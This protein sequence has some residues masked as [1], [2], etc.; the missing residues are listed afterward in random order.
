MCYRRKHSLLQQIDTDGVSSKSVRYSH[1][2][3]GADKGI[4]YSSINWAASE[5]ARFDKTL[6]ENRKVIAAIIRRRYRPNTA[7]VA[8]KRVA[9]VSGFERVAV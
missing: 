7:F 4:E 9:H 2:C 1:G 8:A 6:W 3:A 5:D